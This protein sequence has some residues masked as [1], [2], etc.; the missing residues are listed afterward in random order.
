M[1]REHIILMSTHIMQL[2]R[3]VSDEIVILK[4][5]LLSEAEMGEAGEEEFEQRV[6]QLLE[7]EESR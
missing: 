6:L 5:G 1:K 7:S 4:D 3:D 2:A